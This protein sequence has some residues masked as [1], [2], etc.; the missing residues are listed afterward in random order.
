MF[1][2]EVFFAVKGSLFFLSDIH[3]IWGIEAVEVQVALLETG[4]AAVLM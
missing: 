4:S 1:R 3:E 2:A